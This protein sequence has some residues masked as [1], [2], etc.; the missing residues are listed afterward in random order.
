MLQVQPFPVVSKELVRD[1]HGKSN[2][3]GVTKL[4]G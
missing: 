2:E 1:V 3:R 4:C